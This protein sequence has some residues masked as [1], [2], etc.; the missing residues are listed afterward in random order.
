MLS[1]HSQF[2]AIIRHC[3]EEYTESTTGRVAELLKSIKAVTKIY[4]IVIKNLTEQEFL[5]MLDAAFPIVEEEEK[6]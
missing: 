4:N 1:W 3:R 6:E 2:W 5:K